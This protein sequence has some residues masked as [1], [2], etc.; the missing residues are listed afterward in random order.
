M[1]LSEFL[2]ELNNRISAAKIS[3]FWNEAMKKQWLNNAGERVCNYYNWKALEYAKFT[4]TKVDGEYYD[5]PDEFQENSIYHLEVDSKKYTKIKKWSDYQAC[6]IN[7]STKKVFCSHNGFYFIG[8][9]PSEADLVI[10]IWGIKKWKKLVDNNDEPVTPSELDESIVKLAFATCLQKARKRNG[11]LDERREVE[12]PANPRI[13]GSGGILARMI[14]REEEE[15]AGGFIGQ[16]K[17]S[18]WD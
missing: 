9:T 11:A 7:E 14:A 10:D 2:T 8:P 1:K 3:G 6:R 13:E 5:Y 17:C 18:R 15:P 4:K 12:A 16:A